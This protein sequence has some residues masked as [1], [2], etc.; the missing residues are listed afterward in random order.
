M[1]ACRCTSSI[2][3]REVS[4]RRTPIW[5]ILNEEIVLR[6][7]CKHLHASNDALA[8]AR[9]RW[10]S[11]AKRIKNLLEKKNFPTS[12]YAIFRQLP[13]EDD[14]KILCGAI[15]HFGS[16]ANHTWSK[17]F[18]SPAFDLWLVEAQTATEN[19]GVAFTV[20]PCSDPSRLYAQMDLETNRTQFRKARLVGLELDVPR[21]DPSN[22]ANRFKK[23]V[24][25]LPVG[26][27]GIVG[28]EIHPPVDV[29]DVGNYLRWIEDEF[30]KR[31]FT[32]VNRAYVFWLR[33][34]VDQRIIGGNVFVNPT[35]AFSFHLIENPFPNRR[36]AFLGGATDRSTPDK[37]T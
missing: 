30:G 37:G 15:S 21:I 25:Q 13:T 23:A 28:I 34:N 8:Q 1:R 2:R 11:V 9:K 10:P 4:A 27:P 3:R 16:A 17:A 12:A 29:A 22:F 5:P 36:M 14:I 20:P 18:T 19:T 33:E 35:A 26:G 32:R 6:A 7:E 24:S 31:K